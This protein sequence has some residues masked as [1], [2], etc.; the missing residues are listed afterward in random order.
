MLLLY[1]IDIGL[2]TVNTPGLQDWD[3]LNRYTNINQRNPRWSA[4]TVRDL[5][6]GDRIETAVF[7]LLSFIEAHEE[8]QRKI[9]FYLGETVKADTP[10]EALVVRESQENVRVARARLSEIS[11]EVL[12]Y[13]H[14]KQA[15]RQLLHSEE[16]MVEELRVEGILQ[17][18]D[19]SQLLKEINKD[20][21]R[22]DGLGYQ[23]GCL[24]LDRL[25]RL[26]HQYVS[27][28]IFPAAPS[29]TSQISGVD[30]AA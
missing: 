29:R 14:S 28:I 25:R 15:A 9:P 27:L 20:L 4:F 19:A 26:M 23:S 1:S 11:L 24:W 17:E 22:L 12:Q 2:D 18:T 13:Y 5:F 21:I 30:G 6:G 7:V 10:E 3:Q 16:E 8:A